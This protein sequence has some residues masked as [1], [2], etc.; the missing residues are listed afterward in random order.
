MEIMEHSLKKVLLNL[1]QKIWNEGRKWIMTFMKLMRSLQYM[2][3]KWNTGE[4]HWNPNESV[5][6]DRSI[7]G[8]N[9]RKLAKNWGVGKI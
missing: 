2:F 3:L 6:K 9:M 1:E 8:N 7:W 4:S 5:S